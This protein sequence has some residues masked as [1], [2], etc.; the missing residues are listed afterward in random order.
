MKELKAGDK[1]VQQMTRDGAVE[2]NKATG[3]AANISTR[4]A[5]D[6]F[7]SE[8]VQSSGDDNIIGGVVERVQTERQAAKKNT[9]RKYNAEIYERTQVKPEESRLKFSDAER[10][11]PAMA[12]TVRK[13]ERAANRYEKARAK[14][15]KEKSLAI[16]RVSDKPSGKTETRFVFGEK[17]KPPNGMRLY[18]LRFSCRHR[19]VWSAGNWICFS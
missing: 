14:V 11:D 1:V 19:W 4:A 3:G 7:P 2:V 8:N 10:T 5:P 9:A 6:T 15:P 16:E 12:K 13:S 17:D 18:P